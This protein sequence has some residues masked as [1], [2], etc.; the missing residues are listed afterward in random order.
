[1]N[2]LE[3]KTEHKTFTRP[4]EVREFPNGKVEIL[5]VGGVQIGRMVFQPGWRWSNDVRPLAKTSSCQAPHFQYHVAGRLG[6]RMDDG[7]ELIVGPGDIT[8]LPKGHDAWVIGN[9]PVVVVDWFGA[10]NYAKKS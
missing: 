4:D 3:Q 2:S 9:E 10:S 1:M 5:D 7:T 8:S 6:I